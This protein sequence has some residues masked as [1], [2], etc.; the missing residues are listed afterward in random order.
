MD[1]NVKMNKDAVDAVDRLLVQGFDS[2]WYETTYQRDFLTLR[3]KNESSFDFYKR[4]G[5]ELGHDPHV[6]FSE[7]LYRTKNNDVRNAMVKGTIKTGFYHWLKYGSSE[8]NRH[9]FSQKLA[10][11]T[12]AIYLA[13]DREFLLDTYSK[14]MVGY[15]T[16]IDYYFCRVAEEE[17]SPSPAFSESGYRERHSD[18]NDAIVEK[19]IMSGFEHFL[20]VMGKEARAI[21]SHSQHLKALDDAAVAKKNN[22]TRIA[23]EDN[24]PGVTALSAL[25][26][27]DSMEFYSGK[28]KVRRTAP[29][30]PGGLLV[31]VPNFLPE[32]LFGGYLAFFGYLRQLAA[33]TGIGLQLMLVSRS[34][35]EKYEG[36]LMRMSVKEP[37]VYNMFESFEKFDPEKRQIDIPE[38]YHVISYCGELHRIA[39]KVAETASQK[40]IFF[41]QEYEAEF[42]ANTDM[43]SFNDSAFLLPHHAV[44]NSRKL[45]EF[46]QKKTAVF[47]RAGPEY[48]YTAIEN[49]LQRLELSKE[50][51][52]EL[53]KGRKKRRFIMYGRPEGHAARNHFGMSVLALRQAIRQGVFSGDDWEFYSIGALGQIDDIDLVGEDRLRIM[54]KIPKAEYEEFLQTGDVGMSV[55]TTPHPG[56]VHFQMAAFGLPTVTNKTELRDKVWLAA[57]NRNLVPVEMSPEAI[58]DGF[59]IAVERAEDLEGRYDNA[60]ASPIM[61]EENCLRAALDDL[62]AIVVS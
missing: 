35:F 17:L 52:L 8:V 29:K 9:P 48:R 53:N 11:K 41:I 20:L 45:I 1:A 37:K 14:R 10:E 6:G 15:P 55:I 26:M 47:D 49:P 32:I 19:A 2:D 28:I 54:P 4:I 30:G 58:V 5:G 34:K 42:H 24:I 21:V 36:N 39:L 3:K 27:L 33:E 44:Y 13:L 18:V 56:I 43:R 16:V 38:N 60:L 12:R 40:P 61:D 62:A 23:L 46:F 57:Q 7:I 50:R 22:A 31:L 59:R 25:S 51:F